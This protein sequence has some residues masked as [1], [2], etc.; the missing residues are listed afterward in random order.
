MWG[1]ILGSVVGGLLGGG[2]ESKKESTT[3]DPR[4]GYYVYG[5][6]GRGGLLG[7][8]FPLFRQQFA[9]GGLNDM[10]RGGLEMQRQTLMSPQFTQGYDAMRSMGLGLMAGGVAQNPF[11]SGGGSFGQGGSNPQGPAVV[12]PTTS[13]QYQPFQ[14]QQ[15]PAL[16]AMNTPIQSVSQYQAANPMPTPGADFQAEIEDYLSRIGLDGEGG[17]P[18]ADGFDGGLLGG[19]GLDGGGNSVGNNGGMGLG[20]AMG[21]E[22]VDM[23]S[24]AGNAGDNSAE[25]ATGGSDGVGGTGS[26]GSGGGFGGGSG[27]GYAKGGKVTKN[28]LRGPNPKGPDDGYA[29]LDEGEYII[30]AKAAK[31]IGYDKLAH[32]NRR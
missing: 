23:G 9:Q 18:N 7:D 15:N 8:I 13:T 10:Q 21:G 5:E 20:S 29:A 27:D 12:R 17:S 16:Q 22:G 25:G 26:D 3:I 1:Q 11:T 4:L 2:G 30:N 31:R 24:A 6:N 32:M 14:Y 19:L 28:R